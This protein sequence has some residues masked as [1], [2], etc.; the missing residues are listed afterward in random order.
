M[1]RANAIRLLLVACYDLCWFRVMWFVGSFFEEPT[2]VLTV[3]TVSAILRQVPGSDA[4][5]VLLVLRLES[6]V[7][8]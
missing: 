5:C 2:G 8:A 1:T 3:M 7:A 6:P 4:P